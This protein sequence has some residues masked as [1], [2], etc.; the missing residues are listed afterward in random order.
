M[1]YFNFVRHQINLKKIFSAFFGRY[2]DKQPN[3]RVTER[4]ILIGN[5]QSYLHSVVTDDQQDANI[6]VYLFIYIFIPNQLYMFR[7]M[8][9]PIIRS[10]LLYLQ[11]LILPTGIATGWCHGWDGTFVPSHPWHQPA[12]ISV[13]NIRCCKYS[14]VLLMM[15]E[16]I[17]R[18]M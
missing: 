5:L 18:N 2:A 12:A 16:D 1:K 11:H 13:N 10:T 15:G 8:S 4:A 6:L 3:G 9:S 7:A 14:Q 17:A